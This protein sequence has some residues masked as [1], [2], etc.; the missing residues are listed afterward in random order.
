MTKNR[1]GGFRTRKLLSVWDDRVSPSASNTP[2]PE[3]I[4]DFDYTTAQGIWNLKSTTQFPKKF[5]QPL[6]ISFAENLDYASTS[7]TIAGPTIP[8]YVDNTYVAVLMEFTSSLSGNSSPPSGWTQIIVD[9]SPFTS[10]AGLSVC[11]KVLDENDRDT[12][13]GAILGGNQRDQ[14]YIFKNENGSI[15][16]ITLGPFATS[17]VTG[18]MTVSAPTIDNN[19]SAIVIHYFY[20]SSTS[21]PTVSMNPTPD[22]LLRSSVNNFHGGQYKIYNDSEPVSTTSSA[23]L[24]GTIRQTLFWLLIQ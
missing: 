1:F 18:N 9:P 10:G 14:L 2:V 12:S 22:D 11:Y 8:N 23:T 6:V 13:P 3:T 7:T 5:N 17:Q 15:Q 19:Q 21:T 16:N 20:N 4:Q 24:A